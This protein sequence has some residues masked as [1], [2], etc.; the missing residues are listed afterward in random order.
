MIPIFCFGYGKSAE[1]GDKIVGVYG[2]DE[3]LDIEFPKIISSNGKTI[4]LEGVKVK[5]LETFIRSLYYPI[6]SVEAQYFTDEGTVVML[7]DTKLNNDGSCKHVETTYI[8]PTSSIPQG[9]LQ[10]KED[11]E[12]GVARLDYTLKFQ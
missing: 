4:T 9:M 6:T 5:L 3:L 1:K 8:Y 10:V 12:M 7:F 2:L 11:W